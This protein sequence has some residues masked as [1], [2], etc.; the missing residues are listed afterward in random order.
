MW[1]QSNLQMYLS[2]RAMYEATIAAM[3]IT[4]DEAP[5]AVIDQAARAEAVNAELVAVERIKAL[6]AE[7]LSCQAIG[8]HLDAEGFRTARGG[9]WHSSTIARVING[10]TRRTE[11]PH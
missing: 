11:A 10:H 9:R 7:G 4:L 5:A 3:G 1:R 2:R 8:H 6:R